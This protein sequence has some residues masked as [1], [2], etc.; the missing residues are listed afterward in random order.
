M[1]F[2]EKADIIIEIGGSTF[3]FLDP[4]SLDRGKVSLLFLFFSHNYKY[5]YN[6]ITSPQVFQFYPPIIEALL[7][8]YILINN[9]SL[10]F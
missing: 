2:L 7:R 4:K 10:M 1:F 3:V 8:V 5:I 6:S 9:L